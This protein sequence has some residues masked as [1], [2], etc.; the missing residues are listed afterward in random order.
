M[1]PD[2]TKTATGS[3]TDDFPAGSD[4]SDLAGYADSV[5]ADGVQQQLWIYRARSAQR[6]RTATD[7][8]S[9]YGANDSGVQLAEA[10][11]A[12]S[13]AV[14]AQVAIAHRQITTPAPNVPSNGWAL[15]GVVCDAAG[16]PV[17]RLTVFLVDASKTYQS[18]YGYAYTDDTGQFVL[19]Y[20][21]TKDAAAASAPGK[22]ETALFVEISDQKGRTVYSGETPVQTVTGVAMR[23][24]VVLPA[25]DAALGEPPAGAPK[26]PS[27]KSKPTGKKKSS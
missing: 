24:G 9:Q 6:S 15:Y 13:Q 2:T 8:K 1:T 12:A 7:L 27:T 23:F 17:P 5:A 18:T 14:S 26:G 19:S 3:Q 21:K 22:D 11:L 4:V 25:G 20:E 10:A 16:N